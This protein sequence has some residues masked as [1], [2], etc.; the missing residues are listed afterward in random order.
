V[1]IH[2]QRHGDD[3]GVSAL[4]SFLGVS[5][6]D[7]YAAAASVVPGFADNGG[8]SIDDTIR[9]ARKF[10]VKLTRVHW[11]SVDLTKDSGILWVNWDKARA[12]RTGVEAHWVLL[13]VGTII[14]PSDLSY[15]RALK[16]LADNKGRA[17]TLLREK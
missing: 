3:C 13:S 7:A 2:A 11:R 5:Y 15:D 10:G 1:I 6:G 4:C 12:R 17:G 16:Y 8:L 9:A 14:D